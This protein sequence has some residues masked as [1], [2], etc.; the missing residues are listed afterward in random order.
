MQ[1]SIRSQQIFCLRYIAY[2]RMAFD[3][4]RFCYQCFADCRSDFAC[5]TEDD[6]LLQHICLLISHGKLWAL[7]TSLNAMSGCMLQDKTICICL[8]S[9]DQKINEFFHSPP[10]SDAADLRLQLRRRLS[11]RTQNLSCGRTS[12]GL[13]TVTVTVTAPC[14]RLSAAPAGRSA[15]EC[16]VEY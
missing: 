14:D 15:R 2:K 13:V 5:S 16:G 3:P 6:H 1:D 11:M 7:R 10:N 8:P 4:F 12:D 9:S